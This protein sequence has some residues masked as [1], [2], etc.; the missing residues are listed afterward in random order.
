MPSG[1]SH[2]SM[3]SLHFV[4]LLEPSEMITVTLRSWTRYSRPSLKR[5]RWPELRELRLMGIHSSRI[6]IFG[7]IMRVTRLLTQPSMSL[8][9]R[10]RLLHCQ[11][12]VRS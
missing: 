1:V 8:V 5:M 11:R 3:R 9:E 7:W 10:T 2:R 6:L 12:L 4:V